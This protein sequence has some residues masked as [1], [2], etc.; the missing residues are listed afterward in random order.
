L[1]HHEEYITYNTYNVK[2]I[3]SKNALRY[4]QELIFNSNVNDIVI[5]E[6]SDSEEYDE[7]RKIQ[8]KDFIKNNIYKKTKEKNKNKIGEHLLKTFRQMGFE[9][10]TRVG[11]IF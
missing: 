10:N 11:N 3:G 2:L 9:K 8:I 5:D 1:E 4:K 7:Q 6:I